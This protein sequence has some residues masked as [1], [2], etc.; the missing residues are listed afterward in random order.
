M[1]LQQSAPMTVKI[2]YLEWLDVHW[3]SE[4][5]GPQILSDLPEHLQQY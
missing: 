3:Q 5:E 1:P 4:H 2:R